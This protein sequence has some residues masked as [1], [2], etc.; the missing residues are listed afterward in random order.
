MSNATVTFASKNVIH[1]AI[2]ININETNAIKCSERIRK[3]K[4]GRTKKI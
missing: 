2:V 1:R 3:E 4:C